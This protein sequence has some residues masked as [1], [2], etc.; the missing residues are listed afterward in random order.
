MREELPADSQGKIIVF[1]AT[2][3]RRVGVDEQWYFS[4]IDIVGALTGSASP[5]SIGTP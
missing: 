3:I 1:G 4:V 2:Q 5:Q